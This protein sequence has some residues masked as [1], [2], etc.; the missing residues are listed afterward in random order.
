MITLTQQ[1]MIAIFA[2]FN[3]FV[4]FLSFFHTSI[5]RNPFGLT[6]FLLVIGAFVWADA[7]VFSLFWIF[8]SLISLTMANWDIF[9]LFMVAFW[10]VRSIGESIY[11]FNQQFSTIN[12]N[13]V[14]TLLFHQL[15]PS[16][17]IWFVNQIFWQCITVISLVTLIFLVVKIF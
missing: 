5:R 9:C 3:I 1:V 7:V 2:L 10:L 17:S 11:W 14:N 16:D 4:F 15:F 12:R 6:R 13:P 8:V